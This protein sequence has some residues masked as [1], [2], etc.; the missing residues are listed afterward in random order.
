M[1]VS[2]SKTETMAV[3]REPQ[4]LGID[5]NGTELK[6]TPEFKYLGSIFAEN[7]RMDREIETRCQKAN[8][9]CYQ[10]APLLRHRDIPISTKAKLIKAIFL[11]T[12]TYQ[13]QTW[14][15]T[16]SLQQKLVACEMRCLRKAVKKTRRDKVRNDDIRAMVGVTPVLQ[17]VEEQ[18]V[19][20]FGHLTRMSPD[21]P[22]VRAYTRRYSGGR[23]RGRPRMRW[24]DSIK[25]IFKKKGLSPTQATR[26]A[27]E[28]NLYLPATPTGTSGRKK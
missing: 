2:I 6:Q 17:Y 14:T 18:Q 22:A 15:L 7:A 27:A 10:L 28:R 11:P 13:C 1:K 19:K 3:C 12:L 16:K 8:S 23:P 21:Q 9:I 5:I 24:V 25:N 4:T 20:W 26:L